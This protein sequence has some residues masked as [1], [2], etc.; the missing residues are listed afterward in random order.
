MTL[1]QQYRIY[2][3]TRQAD[4]FVLFLATAVVLH[5]GAIAG[6][7]RLLQAL[8]PEPLAE[9]DAV[10]IEFVYIDAPE[11]STP[12]P[13]TQRRSVVNTTLEAAPEATVEKPNAGKPA[14]VA[15]K[16]SDALAPKS[17]TPATQP[18]SA[19][20]P[21]RKPVQPT[22]PAVTPLPAVAPKA[23]SEPEPD[24]I[25]P[26]PLP[27][28]EPQIATVPTAPP[29][30]SAAA[31]TLPHP[32][33][34]STSIPTPPLAPLPQ[35]EVVPSPVPPNDTAEVATATVPPAETGFEG[36]GLSGAPRAGEASPDAISLAAA[37]DEAMGAYQQAINLRIEQNWQTVS[38]TSS[39][40]ATV[41]FV[42]D[43]G[44]NVVEVELLEPSGL[45]ATDE[46]AIAAIRA[47]TPFDPLPD[48]YEAETLAIRF[49]FNYE[50][51]Q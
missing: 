28:S 2:F 14:P 34:G 48:L 6:S 11:P 38:V 41:R 20:H 30:P 26:S 3:T 18:I 25:P 51:T 47:A 10:P 44:G 45:A 9:D 40:Q 31:D 33:A 29:V 24:K 49:T 22:A 23:A 35:P 42:L 36:T 13:P 46:A 37:R 1:A 19:T 27:D 43:R 12:P 50:V 5:V 16:E 39:R 8:S 4:R 32:P 15:A 7:V 17:I 21:S